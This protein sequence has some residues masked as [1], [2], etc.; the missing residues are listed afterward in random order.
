MCTCQHVSYSGF[1]H[2]SEFKTV[3]HV[4]H[5]NISNYNGM[6]MIRL[7]VFRSFPDVWIY[8]WLITKMASCTPPLRR[9]KIRFFLQIVTESTTDWK[10]GMLGFDIAVGIRQKSFKSTDRGII[11]AGLCKPPY[12]PLSIIIFCQLH[13][14]FQRKIQVFALLIR[15]YLKHTLDP[16]L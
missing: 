13:S 1:D 2:S 15:L 7:C 8:S 11:T 12:A 9:R 4:T 10:E 14:L 6:N 3:N 16:V 5:S